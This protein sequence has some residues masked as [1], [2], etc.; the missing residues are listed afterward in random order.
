[1]GEVIRIGFSPLTDA[2]PLIVAKEQGFFAEQG[3]DIELCKEVSWANIRDKVVFGEYQAAHMLAPMLLSTTL[4][5]AGSIKKPLVTGYSFGLSG[6]AVSVSNDLFDAMLHFESD[7]IHYPEKTAA[8]LKRVVDK[9]LAQSQP[10]LR[11]A[12]VYPFS[13]HYYLLNHW[14]QTGG[15]KA[16]NDVEILVV[17]PSRV[18]QALEEGLIDGYCVGEPWNTHAVKKQVGVTLITG[19]EIWNNAPEKVLAVTK[20][21]AQAHEGEHKKL[22][23]ALYQASAWIDEV[24][25]REALFRLLSRVEYLDAPISSI[26]NTYSGQVVHPQSGESRFIPSFAVPFQFYANFPWQS[27]AQWILQQMIELGQVEADIKLD[28]IADSVYLTAL[29]REV[30]QE[31]GVSVPDFDTKSEGLHSEPWKKGA[32]LLGEDRF[33]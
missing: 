3:L 24:T 15:L 27:H 11:F 8:V 18:V 13:M 10:K 29:Y 12:V 20:E 2:A 6:N 30:M 28:D 4:G 1:M 31:H 22:I 23:W 16:S 14:L 17:P 26:E 33:L 5:A 9:R 19:Y 32:Y 21:W 25:N 7:L